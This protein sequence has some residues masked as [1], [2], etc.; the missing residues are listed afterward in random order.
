[1]EH[2]SVENVKNGLGQEEEDSTEE[3]DGDGMLAEMVNEKHTENE[4]EMDGSEESV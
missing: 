4:T 3:F 2:Q 1:M